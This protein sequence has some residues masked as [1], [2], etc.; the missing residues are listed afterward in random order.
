MRLHLRSPQQAEGVN[1][2]GREIIQ[3]Y[4]W[5]IVCRRVVCWRVMMIVITVVVVTILIILFLN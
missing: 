5:H 1:A 4:T 3:C 2:E